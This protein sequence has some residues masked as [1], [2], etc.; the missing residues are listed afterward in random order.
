[1]SL[2]S[3]TPETDDSTDDVDKAL[4]TAQE[5]LDSIL[6]YAQDLQTIRIGASVDVTYLDLSFV[7]S[8]NTCWRSLATLCLDNVCASEETF[9]GLLQRHKNTLVDVEIWRAELSEGSWTAVFQRSAGTM[10]RLR[11]FTIFG[12]LTSEEHG[13][14]YCGIEDGL[15]DPDEH[16]FVRAL[17]EYM[18]TG[19][20][21]PPT[22]SDTYRSGCHM[23]SDE[24][25]LHVSA[26]V[27]DCSIR[28]DEF[29]RYF[30]G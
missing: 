21:R 25:E 16:R 12:D 2:I 30:S 1:M 22:R 10:S 24:N 18:V 5:V 17:E 8:T 3:S 20:D 23:T 13:E 29:H 6:V 19:G 11:R 28:R 14:E 26:S 7:F 9:V 15:C 4:S 27:C